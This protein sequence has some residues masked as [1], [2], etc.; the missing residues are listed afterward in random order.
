MNIADAFA[1]QARTRP[2]HPAVEDGDTVGLALLDSVEQIA[3]IWAMA[4]VG[5]TMFM[6]DAALLRSGH[7]TRIGGCRLKAV[8]VEGAAPTTLSTVMASSSIQSR[9]RTLSCSIPT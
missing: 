2:D 5:A 8:I 3:L 1:E 7:E 4:R 6:L 9:S